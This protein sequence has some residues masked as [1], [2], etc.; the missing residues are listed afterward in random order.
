MSTNVQA[1]L[2]NLPP[3]ADDATEEEQTARAIL[4]NLWTPRTSDPKSVEQWERLGGLQMSPD[5][6]HIKPTYA[7]W[8]MRR[9]GRVDTDLS[10]LDRTF[11][12]GE[13]GARIDANA[14]LFVEEDDADPRVV[15]YLPVATH[16]VQ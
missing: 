11:R 14:F 16:A 9:D 15:Q 5:D 10:T 13:V 8:I 1:F 2:D 3:L 7:N 4:L 6:T 12:G